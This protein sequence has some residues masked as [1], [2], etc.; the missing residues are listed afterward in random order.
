MTMKK[1]LLSMVM[2][3]FLMALVTSC[4]H[5]NTPRGVAEAAAKCLKNEDY[6]GLAKLA[7][8]SDSERDAFKSILESKVSKNLEQKGGLDSYEILD[9]KINEEA[10]TA[11]VRVKYN[12]GNGSSNTE[13]V[14]LVKRE[15]D[16]KLKAGK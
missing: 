8:V 10:G 14:R 3:L 4:G 2:C 6:K 9:E 11:T 1:V 12:Y 5:D 16:W 13:S 7:D 15:G